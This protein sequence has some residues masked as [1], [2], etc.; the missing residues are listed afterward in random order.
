MRR[1]FLSYAKI[2]L[3]LALKGERPD[4]FHEIDTVL[5]SVDLADELLFEPCPVGDLNVYSDTPDVPSG[6]E[7]LVWKALDLL[8]R[9][10]GACQ[11]MT[12]HLRKRIP[13]QAGLGGGSSNGACALA[14][15]NLIWELGLEPP[16]LEMLAAQLGSDVPFF[17]RGGTQRCLGR[18]EV[19]EPLTPLPD[20]SWVI[21]KPRWNLATGDVFKKAGSAL[22]LNS[23]KVRIILKS[24]AKRD[25]PTV[26]EEGFNDLEDSAID[27][28][29]GATELVAALSRAGLVG[30]RLAGSGSSWVGWHRETTRFEQIEAAGRDHGGSVFLVGP[31][32]RGWIETDKSASDSTRM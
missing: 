22:T 6:K 23:L 5:Q 3:Y 7:N 27:L 20:S 2:N 30:I 9:M 31:T 17:V 10:T 1:R 18:G 32:G 21:V 28:E 13:A 19:L 4:G 15:A 14:A 16:A 8:R 25:L 11:G 24:I 26:G 12:V 29:P